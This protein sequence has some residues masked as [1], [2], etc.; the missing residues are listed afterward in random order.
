VSGIKRRNG[1]LVGW[2]RN[3]GFSLEMPWR[4]PTRRRQVLRLT[5]RVRARRRWRWFRVEI[6][7]PRRDL[8]LGR[9]TWTLE[10]KSWLT[11]ASMRGAIGLKTFVRLKVGLGGRQS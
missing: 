9:G 2:T 8:R 5:V 4:N 11:D 3:A 1:A 10:A 6:A 7:W